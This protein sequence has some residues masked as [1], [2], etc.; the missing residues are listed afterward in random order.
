[1]SKHNALVLSDRVCLIL[2]NWASVFPSPS[3]LSRRRQRCLWLRISVTFTESYASGCSEHKERVESMATIR[4]AV[5]E[6][7]L[8]KEELTDAISAG[9]ST[10]MREMIAAKAKT[11]SPGRW[12]KDPKAKGPTKKWRRAPKSGART[13]KK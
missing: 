4:I 10:A 5:V 11:P 7:E 9:V 13:A 3:G 12:R 1:L 8:P 2:D 6:I